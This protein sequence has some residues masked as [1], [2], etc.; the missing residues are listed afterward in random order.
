MVWPL[1]GLPHI[2][3]IGL[4]SYQIHRNELDTLRVWG[5]IARMKGLKSVSIELNVPQIWRD[6]WRGSEEALL[7]CMVEACGLWHKLDGQN[8]SDTQGKQMVD[9]SGNAYSDEKQAV[10]DKEMVL[11]VPWPRIEKSRRKWLGQDGD[12]EKLLGC[13][14]IWS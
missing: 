3:Y 11:W 4:G 14:V 12:L 5:V 2:S 9:S 1:I 8:N 7:E 13:K 10:W 6:S